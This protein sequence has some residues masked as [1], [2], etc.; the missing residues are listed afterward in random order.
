MGLR[1]YC[2]ISRV[3]GLLLSAVFVAGT[4][5]VVVSGLVG[6]N[7][8]QALN[9]FDTATIR[10]IPWVSGA[11]EVLETPFAPVPYDF[12]RSRISDRHVILKLLI[13]SAVWSAGLVLLYCVAHFRGMCG[14]HPRP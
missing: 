8:L 1:R 4:H 10:T 2:S 14:R 12:P 7:C 9:T 13:N 11:L 5:L 3:S 6:L